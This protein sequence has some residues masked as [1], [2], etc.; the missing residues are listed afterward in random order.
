MSFSNRDSCC[1]AGGL[2]KFLHMY[3]LRNKA[4]IK[5]TSEYQTIITLPGKE[6]D[7]A[8]SKNGL[9]V[10]DPR[11]LLDLAYLSILQTRMKGML[12]KNIM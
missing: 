12:M 4:S 3:R 1:H 6:L 8:P 7:R 5:T 10:Q 2:T 9:C 11:T